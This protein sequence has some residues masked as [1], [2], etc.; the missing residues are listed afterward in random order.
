MHSFVTHCQSKKRG[1]VAEPAILT[2][3]ELLVEVMFVFTIEYVVAATRGSVSLRPL[4]VICASKEGAELC[5]HTCALS[6]I[7]SVLGPHVL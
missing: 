3:F 2:N 6:N 4:C 1:S 7:G 5:I